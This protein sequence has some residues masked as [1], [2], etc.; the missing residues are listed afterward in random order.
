MNVRTLLF[1]DAYDTFICFQCRFHFNYM[2]LFLILLAFV[3][4]FED[5]FGLQMT[6]YIGLIWLIIIGN[7][8]MLI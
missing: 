3:L 8:Y 7:Y 2:L 5:K 6:C 4:K 1:S